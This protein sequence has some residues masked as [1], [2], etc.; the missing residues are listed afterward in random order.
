MSIKYTKYTNLLPYERVRAARRSYF[1][2]LAGLTL[3]IAAL[4][5]AI[6]ALL[7]VPTYFY[8]RSQEVNRQAALTDLSQKISTQQDQTI[9]KELKALNSK[10][11]FLAALSKKPLASEAV[12]LILGVRRQGV[13][14][15]SI[16]YAAT[17]AEKS[18]AMIVTGTAQTRE[19]LRAY[20]LALQGAPF[21]SAVN[22]PVNTYTKDTNISFTMTLAG[23]F[24]P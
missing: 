3:W 5:L 18:S 6:H 20:Q 8:L 12:R 1:V 13:T 22:L 4:L 10:A 11:V 14:L 23:S 9:N 16:S 24:T 2:R 17:T 7:N 21:V 19:A 15:T